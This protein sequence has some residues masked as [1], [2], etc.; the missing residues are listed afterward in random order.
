MWNLM[1]SV[2]TA[3]VELVRELVGTPPAKTSGADG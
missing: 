2:Y 1:H 3:I